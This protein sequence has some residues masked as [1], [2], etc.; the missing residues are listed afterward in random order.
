MQIN[1]NPLVN[2]AAF[3][4][5]PKV[6]IDMIPHHLQTSNSALKEFRVEYDW[7]VKQRKQLAEIIIHEK[8][9][10]GECMANYACPAIQH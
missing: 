8:V 10:S 9:P 4:S 6:M 5:I 7:L 2:T 3:E 1:G